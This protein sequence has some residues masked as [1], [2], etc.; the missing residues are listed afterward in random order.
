MRDPTGA[1]VTAGTI[2]VGGAHIAYDLI[3]SGRPLVLLHA[4]I[5]DR[6][7]WD[8]QLQSFARRFRVLRIDLRGFGQTAADGDPYAHHDDVAAVLDALDMR[9]AF[10]VGAS[11]GGAVAIDLA[12]DRPELVSALVLVAAAVD[13]Y[14]FEDPAT[15]AGWQQAE[16]ALE[17]G[18]QLAAAD[19]EIELW[20]AGPQ[21]LLGEVD[22]ELRASVRDM[23]LRRYALRAGD[24]RER[25]RPAI[26]RLDE[27]DV[28][29]LV[30]VGTLDRP[31]IR[32]IADLLGE[33]LGTART[34]RLAGV[35]HL[36]NLEAPERFNRLV[37]E[38][39]EEVEVGAFGR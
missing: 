36:P 27:V 35:A 9:H 8:P 31:D 3:G 19:L 39:A 14:A 12:L 30:L 22:G 37:L 38:F 20:L 25:E 29:A 16:A 2:T 10:V 15:L 32:R 17:R 26:G 18:D 33:R 34:V 28:P 23:L 24:E 7:M 11:L 13:G 4:G 6:R 5:A 1:D 21:R